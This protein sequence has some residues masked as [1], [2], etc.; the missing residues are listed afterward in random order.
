M[1]TSKYIFG[2][3]FY[4]LDFLLKELLKLNKETSDTFKDSLIK[5][6][7]FCSILLKKS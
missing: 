5:K 4:Y 3:N 1:R 7:R 2:S 6:K